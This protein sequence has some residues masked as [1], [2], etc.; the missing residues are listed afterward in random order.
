MSPWPP[1]A[2]TLFVS[3]S[4]FQAGYEKAKIRAEFFSKLALRYEKLWN[5]INQGLEEDEI[6][7]DLDNL[8]AQ[9]DLIPSVPDEEYDD[10]LRERVYGILVESKGLTLCA[11]VSK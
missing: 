9:E 4:G 5:R 3:Y 8:L 11:T 2:V 7:A 1:L 10:R 6:S